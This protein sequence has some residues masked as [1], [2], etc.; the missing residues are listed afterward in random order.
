MVS[1]MNV[2]NGIDLSATSSV[3]KAQVLRRCFLLPDQRLP[4]FSPQ[5]AD[6]DGQIDIID[7]LPVA[8]T[9]KPT[10]HYGAEL[11]GEAK[12]NCTS[13]DLSVSI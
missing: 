2:P 1:G 9:N 3:G 4:F 7:G 8:V 12:F 13:V 11:N 5:D 10:R 6:G